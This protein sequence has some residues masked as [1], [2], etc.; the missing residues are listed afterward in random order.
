MTDEQAPVPFGTFRP[1]ERRAMIGCAFASGCICLMPGEIV[2][3]L[4]S[5]A[6]AGILLF[7]HLRRSKRE[8]AAQ[9]TGPARETPSSSEAS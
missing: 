4:I 1:S 3:A 6:I 7:W 8:N 9:T 2:G 5:F